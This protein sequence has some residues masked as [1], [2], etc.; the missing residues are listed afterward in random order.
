MLL[1]VRNQCPKSSGWGCSQPTLDIGI[2][3]T[4]FP[5]SHKLLSDVAVF[6]YQNRWC[7][8]FGVSF[9]AHVCPH[10]TELDIP[11]HASELPP[12]FSQDARLN[13]V[14]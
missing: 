5:E 3:S 11:E 9:D 14:A 10:L 8:L 4:Q 1:E 6:V 7:I 13:I 12:L 2:G